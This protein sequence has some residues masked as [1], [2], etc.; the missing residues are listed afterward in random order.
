MVMVDKKNELAEY[1]FHEGTNF[2]SYDFL[3]SFLEE[4]RCTFRVWAPNAHRVYVTGDFC[5]W[6]PTSHE[7]K[8]ITDGG[9]YEV[10]IDGVKKYDCYK[11]VFETENSKFLYKSDPY[12]KHFE[13]RPSTSSKVYPIEEYE[14]SDKDW[15]KKRE[16]P[17]EKPMNI[18]EVHLG[19]WR[20]KY[21]GNFYSYR[22]LAQE[23]VKYVKSMN[24]TH[25]EI[26]PILEHP[27][28]KS[29]GY[30]VTGYFAPT[31]R[32]GLP[33]DFMNF[34]DECHKNGIG[35]I[36]DWVPG[37]FPKDESGLCEFDGGYVYE[38][39]DPNKMEHK[40]WGTRVFDYG[41]KEVI[42]FLVS[43]ASYWL[44]KYHIDGLRVDAVS[45]MLYLDYGRN[46]GQW[47]PNKYGKNENLEVIDFFRILNGHIKSKF[48]GAFMVAEE[49]T[50]WPKV[51]HSI[52]DGGLGFDFKWNMGWM[53]D[54][55]KYLEADPFFR[56]DMH[57]NLTF[58]LTYAFSE[59]Y[60]LP[61]SHDEVVHGKKSI[62]DRATV[63]FDD[64]FSSLKAYLGYM[65]A[66]PGK[67]LTFMG[68][69][70]AQV[71]EWDESK[72]LDWMLLQYEN[73]SN[74]QKFIKELNKVY[75]DNPSLWESD[76]DWQGFIWNTVDDMRNNVFAFT[77]KSKND[78]R[79]MAIC[80]FSS[81]LLKEYKIG[82]D[83]DKPFKVLINSDAKKFG[84]S[85]LIN[86]NILPVEEGFNGF[87]YHISISIPPF[88]AIYLINK[89]KK[90]TQ[91]K[92]KSKAKSKT[93]NKR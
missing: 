6:N 82:V 60:I 81:Q 37:H 27:F 23:L 53:N 62:L 38:Y 2:K 28:D 45:S 85:G 63:E 71:I 83:T 19:S 14:W 24:Y 12:A 25:I 44:D 69:D 65:Y 4:G 8:K 50:A 73:H 68:T 91:S 52:E 87:K 22:D 56:K 70:L 90:S 3:G 78:D 48:K 84:G 76:N 32:Y 75:K 30:Q 54:S 59:N 66:H 43:N 21:D 72:E 46:D 61:L 16:I 88:S 9:V 49:S 17:Y 34:V 36:L 92:V 64:K 74:N 31:S 7:M 13:T 15:M 58:S 42:S 40:E 11:F 77:R 79:V 20:K 57:N 89:E 39:S 67:K 18:Y 26:L 93:T 41:R 29:W 10:E 47:T 33:E 80:N 5:E 51:T 35:V 86:R 55:L 1:L